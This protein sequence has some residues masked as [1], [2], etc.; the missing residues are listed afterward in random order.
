[1]T[2][3]TSL[4]EFDLGT[5]GGGRLRTSDLSGNRT[6]LFFYPKDDTP[7]CTLES[8]EFSRLF[9]DFK[10]SGVSVYGVSPDSEKSHEKFI[11]KCELG[12]PLVSDP[13]RVLIGALDLWVP[14]HYMGRSYMG[15]ERST[16][17]I[18]PGGAIEREWRQVKPA[19]HATEVLETVRAAA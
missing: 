16:F 15:V 14:K 10:K 2:V 19:G 7:G 18:G 13:D 17:V 8:K 12:V 11:N 4:P 5:S 6:V 3:G 9:E 1:M